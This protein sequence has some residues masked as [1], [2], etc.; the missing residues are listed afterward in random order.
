MM[1]EHGFVHADPHPGNLLVRRNPRISSWQRVTCALKKIAGLEVSH[2]PQL[3]ILDHGLYVDIPFD[4]RRDWCLLWRS[5]VLGQRKILADVS[6]RLMPSGGSILTAALSFGFFS[7]QSSIFARVCADFDSGFQYVLV[8]LICT[9]DLVTSS[10]MKM[11]SKNL[12]SASRIFRCLILSSFYKSYLGLYFSHF[13]R[14]GSFATMQLR[15]VLTT[16]DA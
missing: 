5:L 1:F 15:W 2:A 6:N 13:D 11:K 8:C 9:A 10:W 3:V 7:H 12:E 14:R 4:V 16:V